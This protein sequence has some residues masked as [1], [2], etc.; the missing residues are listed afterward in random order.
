MMFEPRPYRVVLQIL[1]QEGNILAQQ[2]P[3][4]GAAFRNRHLFYRKCWMS[5]G[6]MV[7]PLSSLLGRGQNEQLGLMG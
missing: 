3:A 5:S 1:V 6:G 7:K 2:E 4:T